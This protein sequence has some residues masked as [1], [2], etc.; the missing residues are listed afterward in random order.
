[1]NAKVIDFNF[2]NLKA[3]DREKIIFAHMNSV[4]IIAKKFIQKL[5]ANYELD[6]LVSCGVI[7]LMDAIDRYDPR[8]GVLFKTYA[9][10]RIKGQ[11][12]D[13][14]RSLDWASRALRDKIKSHERVVDG[15]DEKLGRKATTK[16]ICKEMD[17]EFN[18]YYK[19]VRK[20]QPVKLV[21]I[22]PIDGDVS[23]RSM[24]QYLSDS[25]DFS[26]PFDVVDY[27]DIK[28]FVRNKVSSLPERECKVIELYYY[29]NK[30]M[31]EISKIL[32]LT[33]SR[34][35]QLHFDTVKKLTRKVAEDMK[36]VA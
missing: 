24:E 34:I 29:K 8:H 13:E 2:S 19:M 11:I 31:K 7:G 35:S 1:M 4:K 32:C 18:D 27:M 10:H 15:L 12:L 25:S 16:E 20:I 22:L 33:E 9:E 21:S 36:L 30:T 23:H 3:Q 6:D 17:I 28:K 5:P 26:D 14:L